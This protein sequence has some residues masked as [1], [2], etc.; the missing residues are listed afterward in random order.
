MYDYDK[1]LIYDNEMVQFLNYYIIIR[2]CGF[3]SFWKNLGRFIYALA[4]AEVEIT[5]D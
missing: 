1:Q 5:L 4:L 2:I 3:F